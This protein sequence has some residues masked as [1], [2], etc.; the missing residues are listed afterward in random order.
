MF[1]WNLSLLG[2][3][4]QSQLSLVFDASQVILFSWQTRTCNNQLQS[5]GADTFW[6]NTTKQITCWCNDYRSNVAIELSNTLGHGYVMQRASLHIRFVNVSFFYMSLLL[7]SMFHEVSCMNTVSRG[8][9]VC[10][11]TSC[12]DDGKCHMILTD[13]FGSNLCLAVEWS[14][15]GWSQHCARDTFSTQEWEC[16]RIAIAGVCCV[17][18]VQVAVQ[19]IFSEWL[20]HRS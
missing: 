3:C 20:L 6:I 15:A 18:A 9:Y 12:S 10:E 4:T 11:F 13:C 7:H 16:F 19:M 1:V 5:V 2:T 8:W 14:C 17:S